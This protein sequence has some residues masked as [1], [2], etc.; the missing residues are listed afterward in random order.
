MSGEEKRGEGRRREECTA[1]GGKRPKKE[2]GT[3][4]AKE[5]KGEGKKW[6]E[7]QS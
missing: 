5:E 3:R 2:V 1:G 7:V 6:K 4:S